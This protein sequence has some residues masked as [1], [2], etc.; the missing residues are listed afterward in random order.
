MVDPGI[1]PLHRGIVAQLHYGACDSTSHA[2]E[3]AAS[4]TGCA[5]VVCTRNRP[6][7]L[8]GFL[9]SL[10][11]QQPR[12]RQLVI[13]DSSDD[14]RSE[15]LLEN[16]PARNHL[17]HCVRYC[18]VDHS[19]AGLTRQRTFALT[20]VATD[21]FASFDDDI[22]LRPECLAVMER[23]LRAH[24]DAVGVGACIDNKSPEVSLRWRLRRLL[25][26][27]PSLAPGRYFDSGVSTP[28]R[29]IPHGEHLIEG[30]WLPGGAAM[31]RTEAARAAGYAHEL[32]GYGYGE[33]LDFSLRMR[34]AGRLLVAGAA[35]LLHLQEG[36][37]RPDPR[38]LGFE[39]LRNR[40]Y[41]RRSAAGASGRRTLW[42]VYA[43]TIETL[44]EAANVV[45]PRQARR[46]I[47]YLRGV[48]DFL[49]HEVS[50]GSRRSTPTNG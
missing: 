27:V 7:L 4:V 2:T 8:A 26:V 50:N 20:M 21:M 12:P 3:A 46:T 6:E 43:M 10:A 31:W 41:T 48:G 23:T 1:A 16:H 13:V 5:V 22:V 35:R 38:R 18:R 25:L 34:R 14:D 24:P 36:G 11:V 39:V 49:R 45:R 33:D 17:A 29:F 44:L 40:L 37:G 28:W 15:R 42:F 30:D 9:N 19:R 47:Q 32:D